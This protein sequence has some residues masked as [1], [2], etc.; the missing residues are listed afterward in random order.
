MLWNHYFY[1]KDVLP[2]VSALETMRYGRGLPVR[3]QEDFEVVEGLKAVKAAK[4]HLPTVGDHRRSLAQ[5]RIIENESN[6][7]L[8]SLS[9]ATSAW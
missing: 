8:C 9:S 4:E 2:E 5:Q 1:L 7:S 6:V 3:S